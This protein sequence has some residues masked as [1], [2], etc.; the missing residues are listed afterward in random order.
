[1]FLPSFPTIA[2][3]IFIYQKE[4]ARQLNAPVL[5]AAI[6]M[7]V[8]PVVAAFGIFQKHFLNIDISGGLKG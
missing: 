8:V 6:L 3:G 1:L 7:S 4:T 2:S 5:F